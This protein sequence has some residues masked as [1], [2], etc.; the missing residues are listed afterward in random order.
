M[1]VLRVEGLPVT[2]SERAHEV[3]VKILPAKEG[4]FGRLVGKESLE[5]DA[6]WTFAYRD[7]SQAR[8]CFAF[9][10]TEPERREL[11]RLTLPLQWFE[12][13]AVVVEEYPCRALVPELESSSVMATIQVHLAENGVFTEQ[14]PQGRLLVRPAWKRPNSDEKQSDVNEAK[15]DEEPRPEMHPTS[16]QQAEQPGEHLTSKH[17]ARKE[18]Q[19]PEQGVQQ[20]QYQYQYPPAPY[21][22]WQGQP[23]GQQ[24]APQYPQMWQY[25]GGMY[26]TPGY[27][28]PPYP[29]YD[30]HYAYQY[31]VPPPPP[32]IPYQVRQPPVSAGHGVSAPQR[33]T[34]VAVPPKPVVSA[35]E[36]PKPKKK[37]VVQ[38]DTSLGVPAL[39]APDEEP[40]SAFG[41]DEFLEG[42]LK[43][44]NIDATKPSGVKDKSVNKPLID[45]IGTQNSDSVLPQYPNT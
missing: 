27:P 5:C 2:L 30:G 22:V 6:A 10:E 3:F 25:P 26:G 41:N 8:V 38:Q 37:P 7:A 20:Y 9:F 12:R 23:Y 43:P 11:A 18:A 34:M 31:A 4:S 24:Q 21:P 36:K 33:Q 32:P 39:N 42:S 13:N 29:A 16:Q 15:P 1:R 44:L 40:I 14:A 35:V 17:Q 19:Q 45:D 28:M